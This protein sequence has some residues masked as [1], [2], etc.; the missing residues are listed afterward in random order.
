MLKRLLCATA[1]VP[2]LAVAAYAAD[3]QPAPDAADPVVARVDGADIRRSEITALM[4]QLPPNAREMS[5][6]VVIPALIDQVVN[7]RLIAAAGYKAKLQDTPEVKDDLKKAEERAVQRAYVRKLLD[8]KITPSMLE[9]AY[10]QQLA[11]NPPS[12]EVKASHILVETEDEAKAIIAELKKGGDFAKLSK[13]KSK[14]PAAAAQGGDLGFFNR[15]TMVPEF[16]DAAFA[17]KPGEISEKPVKTQFGWHVIKVA[18]R[19][20]P[21]APTFE[22]MK[23]D[24][25]QSISQ[26]VIKHEIEALRTAAKVEIMT[27]PTPAAPAPAASAAPAPQK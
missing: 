15:D 10:K 2:M 5:P 27:P 9:N 17:M 25:E 20:T 1:L 11:T 8:A 4:A 13:E 7:Q 19:R 26:D 24:L 12:E 22:E 16:A 3:A 6:D 18:D 14:D 23:G 21:P